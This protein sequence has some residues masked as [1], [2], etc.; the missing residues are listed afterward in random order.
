MYKRPTLTELLQGEDVSRLITIT[1]VAQMTGIS[2]QTL[3]K[4]IQNGMF[5]KAVKFGR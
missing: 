4:A 2:K 3:L 1:Q 5:P